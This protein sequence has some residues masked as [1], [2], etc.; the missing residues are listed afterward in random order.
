[1]NLLRL[2]GLFA[3]FCGAASS[4][5]AQYRSSITGSIHTDK[6]QP[7][8]DVQISCVHNDQ[9]ITL[10]SDS[11]GRFHWY[12]VPPGVYSCRFKHESV[13]EVAAYETTV[14][15]GSSM[16]LVII[17]YPEEDSGTSSAWSIGKGDTRAPDISMPERFLSESYIQSLPNSDHIWSLLNL[18]EPAV[19][20]DRYD[21][22]GLD[23][24]RP[25]LIGVRGSSWSQNQGLVNGQTVSHPSGDGML[26]FPDMTTW[27]GIIYTVGDSPTRHTG[28]GAHIEF[29]PK[30]G[31]RESHGQAQMFFQSG[32]L[33]NDNVT[34]RQRSFLITQ[35]DERWK[36]YLNGAFEVGGPLG[37]Q[38]GW[39]YFTAVSVRNLQKWVRNQPLPI[40]GAV[41]QETLNL[42]GEPSQKDRLSFYF[43]GQQRY[44]PQAEASPQIT[45]DS[46]IN[47]HQGYRQAQTYWTRRPSSRSLLEAR[48]GLA[49]SNLKSRFQPADQVQSTEELFPGFIIDGYYPGVPAPGAV[50]LSLNNTRRGPGPLS[51]SYDASSWEGSAVYSNVRDGFWH[52]NHRMSV[53]GSYHDSSLTQKKTSIGGINLLSFEGA[54]NS[55]RLLN[56]PNQTR[57][58]IRLL[59]F[60]AGDTA[61]FSRLSVT[62]SAFADSSRGESDLSSGRIVNSLPWFNVGGR[63]G[64]AFQATNRWPLVFRFGLA[65]IYDQ[66]TVRAWTASNP[67]GLGVQLY[68]WDDVNGDMQFQPGENTKILKV[69]GGPYTRMDPNLK[70]PE[71]LEH[72]LG[73]TQGF[74]KF[75]FEMFGFRRSSKQLMSLVNEG[76]PFSSYTP[77][78]VIDPGPDGIRYTSDDSMVTVYNQSPDS[79]GHDRYVLT[80]PP[81]FSGHS[82]GMELKLRFSSTR[83]QVE[84]VVTRYRAVGTTAPGNGA[85]QNDTS[86]FLG[87]F[88][89]PNKGIFA[90]GSTFF[91]RGTLARVQGVTE[92]P[93]K[94]RASVIVNYQ[95]GLPYARVLPVQGLNQGLIGVL[96]SQ[97]GSGEV[98]SQAGLMTTH[99]ETINARLTRNFLIKRKSIAA[100][101]DVFNLLNLAQPLLQNDVTS[102]SEHWRV[103]LRT[104]APRSLQL[105][106]RHNW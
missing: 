45:R 49:I 39:N 72:T 48:F 14:S 51:T 74:G 19:V 100:T 30:S 56:T 95:D 106:I 33:Q 23:S 2:T 63:V 7:V 11:A 105:G 41:G 44:E 66:P 32:A 37:K 81:G 87:V 91:D 61:S 24:S 101:L 82:E 77:L 42:S 52:S 40:S 93:L 62:L 85:H 90:R 75:V 1:M 104:E 92:L 86:A 69:Y 83:T 60:Y 76:V 18:T 65:K 27:E 20:A 16:N 4:G 103:P 78:Q 64:A 67:D 15:V 59:E 13:A 17:L 6:G 99:Y 12:F 36:Y 102:K 53:G 10:V 5:M 35:S 58:R 73:L 71:T 26:A 57:D 9:S 29:I 31:H 3:I 70:N 98:G 96:T 80:N 89:D 55:V 54:P 28:P 38:P 97:R 46:S 22:A 88:D 25:F 43:S 50:F 21:P 8:V 34:S 79:L 68:K 47:Q 84:T 94:M